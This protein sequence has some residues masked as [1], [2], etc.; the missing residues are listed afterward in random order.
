MQLLFLS[1]SK[2]LLWSEIQRFSAS[3]MQL[4]FSLWIEDAALE[5]NSA[6][7]SLEH[8]ALWIEEAALERNSAIFSLEHAA[9]FSFWIEDAALERNSAIFSLEHAAVFFSPWIEDAALERNS[10]I[11]SL[12][13]AAVFSLWRR[14]CWSEIDFF[15]AGTGL[16]GCGCSSRSQLN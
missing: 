4:F 13:H 3:N 7:F 9:V 11:F 16:V 12:E 6:I 1:G 10:A 15:L 14:G 2:T 5:R 8:A